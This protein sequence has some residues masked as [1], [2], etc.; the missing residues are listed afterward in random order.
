MNF[1][2]DRRFQSLLVCGGS[3]TG[4]TS[5]IFE[6]IIAQD[7]EKKY[8]FTEASK[9][10]GFTALKTGIAS[11]SAPYSNDYLNKNFSLNMLSPTF[12]KDTLFNT[13]VKKMVIATSPYT[14][15]L[16]LHICLLI[17]RL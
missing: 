11:L 15:T 3:G 2:E 17:M 7:I 16:V 12:G 1:S 4:K 8:F 13:F 9:E 10:L 5:M 6:P 14:K